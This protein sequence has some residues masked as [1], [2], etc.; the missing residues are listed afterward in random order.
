MSRENLAKNTTLFTTAL[1]VQKALSF[2]YFVLVARFIGV[3]NTGKYTFALSFTTIFAMFLDFGLSQVLIRESA[4]NKDN[5]QRYLAGTLALKI[6][7][8][9]IIYGA[10]ILSVNLMGYPE[11]TRQMV[12]VSG[13][14]MILDSFT[15]SFY[16]V[17]R[18]QQKL[19]YESFGVMTNQLIV[20][21]V[22]FI[23]LKLNL[24][25]I[26]LIVVYLIGS[27][28]N[29]FYSSIL[30]K[31]RANILPKLA[32][33]KKIFKEI[34]IFALPFGIAAF[35]IR[36]YSTMDTVL[37]SKL[38]G[39]EA[40]G[41]YSVAYKITF[42]LQFV[43]VAFSA[44]FY[45]AFCKYFIESKTELAKAFTRSMYYLMIL[46]LPISAGVMTLADKVIGPI[47]GYEYAPAVLPLQVLISAMVFIFICFPIGALL[48]ACNKQTRNTVHLAIVALVNLVLNFILIPLY[49]YTGAA[50]AS[51]ISYVI[52]FGLGI[53]VV[54]H[55]I[56][57]DKKY[58]IASFLKI[59]AS[60]LIMAGFILLTKDF[61]HFIILIPAGAIIYLFC[62]IVL[63]GITSRDILQVKTLL[64]KK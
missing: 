9:I 59:I 30:L 29:F 38:A 2:I 16:S 60:C 58:L 53:V 13:I 34:L 45:P 23:G 1:A 5:A 46:S 19:K 24:G 36:M 61:V 26:F 54:Q 20:L 6:L 51:L 28:F 48:N 35:F 10:V 55:I 12:Y 11:I 49:S 22:G 47:F 21:I 32:F 8:S 3:E 4:R 56:S 42:A 50:I 33:D 44:S 17:L 15:L 31:L 37:L 43:A 7:G 62:L 63:R 25:L 57:Y 18:G 27:L 52:M 40:V 14:V 41:I 64:L 39:D